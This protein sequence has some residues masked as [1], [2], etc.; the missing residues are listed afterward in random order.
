MNLKIIY[1]NAYN[2][3]TAREI[4]VIYEN[5]IYINAFCKTTKKPKIF[6]KDRVLAEILGID[7]EKTKKL[8]ADT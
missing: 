1:K 3:V 2:E 8:G 5:D 6:R 4:E 7:S